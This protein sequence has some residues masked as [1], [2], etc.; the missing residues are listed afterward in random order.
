[1]SGP[2]V[3]LPEIARIPGHL[4]ELLKNPIS[5]TNSKESL[6]VSIAMSV[7]SLAASSGLRC[8]SRNRSAASLTGRSPRMPVPSMD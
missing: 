1:M 8:V 5:L 2:G 3:G 7:R 6:G 4:R